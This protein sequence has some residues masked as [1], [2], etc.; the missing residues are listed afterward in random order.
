MISLMYKVTFSAWLT[1]GKSI[2][3]VITFPKWI[4]KC[5]ATAA[6]IVVKQATSGQSRATMEA[7]EAQTYFHISQIDRIRRQVN[8][9]RILEKRYTISRR[10]IFKWILFRTEWMIWRESYIIWSMRWR[11]WKEAWGQWCLLP[12]H[13]CRVRKKMEQWGHMEQN[14]I[15]MIAP[16]V[17]VGWE[18]YDAKQKLVHHQHVT[19]QRKCQAFAAWSVDDTSCYHLETRL[20]MK[21]Y[22]LWY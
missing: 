8:N 3:H 20:D 19:F 2:S 4:S 12:V 7:D 9:W 13:H 16:D 10:L 1:L 14:G 17:N 11:K 15:K 5:G 18:N 6:W 22:Q 21:L